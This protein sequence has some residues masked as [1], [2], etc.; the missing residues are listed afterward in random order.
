MYLMTA[1]TEEPSRKKLD[2]S[3]FEQLALCTSVSG[4]SKQLNM[5]GVFLHV[6]TDAVGSVIV[7]AT[8]MVSLYLPGCDVIKL[9]MDPTLR[10]L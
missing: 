6:L 5:Q 7:I 1:V 2:G 8:A 10:F 9:Y 4:S 3:Y